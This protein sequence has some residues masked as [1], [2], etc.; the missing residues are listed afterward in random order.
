M[1]A[2]EL[3]LDARA[4]ICEGP[5][6]SPR[7]RCLYW[8]DILCGAVHRF[9][10]ATGTDRSAHVP[11]TVGAVV[12]RADGG[13]AVA[14]Q[15]GF[16]GFDFETAALTPWCDP[17]A[18]LP[19]NRFNDGKCDPSGRFWAGTCPT[20]AGFQP[21]GAL[22]VLDAARA[23]TR[24]VEGVSVSN[25]LCWSPDQRTLY[26]IDTATDRIDAYACDPH[27]AWLGE[28]RTVVAIDRA[29][30][31]L[32]DG[33]CIDADGMLWSA[34]WGGSRVNRW[35]PRTGR[36]IQTVTLPV[37][38]VT[39]CAFGGAGLDELYITTARLGLNAEQ[40]RDQPLAGGIF[41]LRTA[42]V[43]V[44]PCAFAG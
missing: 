14:W 6:W 39:S 10:P 41:R 28:R 3:V 37:T 34:H 31:G 30:H 16:A 20:S 24:L 25:G 8:V 36:L 32:L 27:A 12:E 13:L 35:D 22:Y 9:D 17:E 29:V 1:A 11:G 23:A 44:A 21:L 33:M 15:H 5:V 40:A 38:N 4:E 2:P 19:G 26:F 42:T 43:G 18:H 7:Q